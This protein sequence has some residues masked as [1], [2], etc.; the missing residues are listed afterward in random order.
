MQYSVN[1][2]CDATSYEKC[3]YK[4]NLVETLNITDANLIYQAFL[5]SKKPVPWKYDTQSYQ[6]RYLSEI[7]KLQN[8]IINKTYEFFRVTNSQ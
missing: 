1:E 4:H 8:E 2:C 7:A 3:C 5:D 6:T